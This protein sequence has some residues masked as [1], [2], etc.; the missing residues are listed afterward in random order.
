MAVYIRA[1]FG[2]PSILYKEA[3][4]RNAMEVASREHTN[5]VALE[6]PSASPLPDTDS[7]LSE[8]G[9]L[10][11]VM[12]FPTA[13]DGSSSPADAREAPSDSSREAVVE[14]GRVE[15]DERIL[16]GLLWP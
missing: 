15:L 11:P 4:E 16:V 13:V 2:N 12:A 7:L 9:A 3:I 6:A 5:G 10:Y 8:L 1:Q 14:E